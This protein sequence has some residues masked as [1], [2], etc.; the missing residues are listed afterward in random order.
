MRKFAFRQGDT[1]VGVELLPPAYKGGLWR[2]FATLNSRPVYVKASS[3]GVTVTRVA[4]AVG[5]FGRVEIVTGGR[6]LLSSQGLYRSGDHDSWCPASRHW[7]NQD[8]LR[9]RL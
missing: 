8:G 4:A 5:K 1:T 6:L 2:L 7:S 9:G 3:G